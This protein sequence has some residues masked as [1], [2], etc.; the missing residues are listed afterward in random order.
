MRLCSCL[1]VHDIQMHRRSHQCT[2]VVNTPFMQHSAPKAQE[3]LREH[4]NGGFTM[5]QRALATATIALAGFLAIAQPAAAQEALPDNDANP[6]AP[7]YVAPSGGGQAAG[8]QGEARERFERRRRDHDGNP[9]GPGGGPGTNWE[10]RPGPSGGP[11]TSPDRRW[12]EDN[13]GRDRDRWRD[14]DNWRDRDQWNNRDRWRS[15]PH[16]PRWRSSHYYDGSFWY[17]HWYYGGWDDSWR[18]YITLRFYDDQFWWY[19]DEA[20]WVWDQR[21]FCWRSSSPRWNYSY[22][23]SR[24]RDTSWPRQWAGHHWRFCW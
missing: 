3:Q 1:L 15:A 11:G 5:K 2:D 19:Y 22:G 13:H 23:R 16:H 18:W 12:R 4:W 20:W 6:S 8:P 21:R 9:P 14:R 10:N 24:W 7:P 17:P